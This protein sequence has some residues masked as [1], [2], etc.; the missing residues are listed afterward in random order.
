MGEHVKDVSE[1]KIWGVGILIFVS[2][3]TQDKPF[4]RL[5]KAIE[6]GIDEGLIKEKVVVQAG[7]TKYETDKMEIHQVLDKDKLEK[8]MKTCDILIA[9]GGIGTILNGLKEGKPVIAASR[10]AKY[11]E[12]VNDHQAQIVGE[13]ADAGYIIELKDFDELG[14]II[15]NIKKYKVK[16]FKS[17]NSKMLTILTEF[18]EL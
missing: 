15:K 9:H 3:G 13:F 5:L 1:S 2:L 12:H 7:F 17:D 6:K 14:Q 8:L 18:M 10:L 16:K 11:G 4:E